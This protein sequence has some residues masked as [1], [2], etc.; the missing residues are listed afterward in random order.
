MDMR[1]YLD[2]FVANYNSFV[3]G[4]PAICRS[5]S[6]A[7]DYCDPLT[8]RPAPDRFFRNL[9]GGLFADVSATSGIK[10]DFGT[11]SMD[12]VIEGIQKK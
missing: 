6:G 12:F 4:D 8:Y 9:G 11:V 5:P 3:I 2:L 7:P 10:K 1:R